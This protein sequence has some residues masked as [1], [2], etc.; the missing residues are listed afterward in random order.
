MIDFYV[1]MHRR[2]TTGEIFYVGKGHGNRAWSKSGRSKHWHNVVAKDGLVVEIVTTGLQEWYALEL[3]T[4]LIALHG[5]RD[6]GR[7]P[8]V[9]NTDGGEGVSGRKL[10]LESRRKLSASSKKRFEDPTSKKHYTQHLAKFN[11]DAGLRAKLQVTQRKLF[12]R[13]IF[14]VETGVSY[15]SLTEAVEWLKSAGFAKAEGSKLADVADGK[16]IRAYGY[17]WRDLDKTDVPVRAPG[18]NAVCVASDTLGVV[19][20]SMQAAEN[21]VRS[22]INEKASKSAICVTAKGKVKRAYGH[23]WRYATLEET[24]ALKEKGASCAPLSVLTV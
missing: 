7:G 18:T 24:A 11:S 5:R 3:E 10:S 13:K 23:T 6:T 22:T 16:R 17:L 4:S 14:C 19:F 8:L 9:N 2:A 15:Q 20:F 1:Y 12:G 21:F